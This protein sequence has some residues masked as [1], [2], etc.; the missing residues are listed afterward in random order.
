[1]AAPGRPNTR[2]AELKAIASRNKRFTSNGMGYTAV[3]LR[4]VMRSCWKIRAGIP[5]LRINLKCERL[6]TLLNF[7]HSNAGFNRAGYPSAS[8]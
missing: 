2:M 7:Q 4:P 1:M 5:V 3:Q 8:S 6:E